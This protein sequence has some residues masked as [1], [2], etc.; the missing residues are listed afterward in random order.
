MKTVTRAVLSWRFLRA[1]AVTNGLLGLTILVAVAGSLVLGAV[2]RSLIRD[3]DT[4]A[5][6]LLGAGH[7]LFPPATEPV[8]LGMDGQPAGWV[9]SRQLTQVQSILREEGVTVR[10]GLRGVA[11]LAQE[12][13]VRSVR[14]VSG[15]FSAGALP[16]AT[17]P[18]VTGLLVPL[19]VPGA[20]TRPLFLSPGRTGVTWR[21]VPQVSDL[22]I[23]DG[24]AL[25]SRL[26]ADGLVAPDVVGNML[27]L[28]ADEER[29]PSVVAF[30]SAELLE[31]TYP[32]VVV[33]SRRDLTGQHMQV[34]AQNLSALLSLLLSLPGLA[35]VV[36]V[37]LVAGESRTAEFAVLR[38]LG[39]PDAAVRGLLV[40]EVW[41]VSVAATLLAA[42]LAVAGTVA[43]R[44][45]LA[46]SDVTGFLLAGFVLPPGLS[47]LAARKAL[48]RPLGDQL[49][50][51]RS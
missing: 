10:P 17:P 9:T 21:S 50:E 24:A 19:S 40:R 12:D 5:A 15:A 20:D 42:S 25:L 33:A 36:G 11:L 7:V 23:V 26:A 3:R 27:V 22:V 34:S 18:G 48:S 51:L 13:G 29:S 43:A 45:P 8:P 28:H 38:S 35:A 6:E 2:A 37:T 4:A 30:N 47:Y 46:A 49:A 44:V 31:S 32:G 1:H 39:F 16:P 41:I 14:F